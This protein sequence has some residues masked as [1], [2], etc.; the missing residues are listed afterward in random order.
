MFRIKRLIPD[1]WKILKQVRLEALEDTPDAFGS[2]LEK[3]SQYDESDWQKG[4]RRDDCITYVALLNEDSPI[5]LIVGAPYDEKAGLYAM[6]VNPRY[7]KKGV[8]SCLVDAVIE[9]ARESGFSDILLDVADDN[10]SAIALYKSKGFIPTGIK[11]TLPAPREH[12]T[13]HQRI[14]SL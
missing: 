3:A 13:E 5:G 7:R 11:G 9:W 10:V 2:T 6:W 4:L 12:I 1:Q 14:L 8:G